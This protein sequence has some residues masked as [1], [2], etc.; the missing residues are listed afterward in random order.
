MLSLTRSLILG[1]QAAAL[2]AVGVLLSAVAAQAQTIEWT[3][4]PNVIVPAEIG[5]NTIV[6]QG[7]QIMFDAIAD[8]LY[9]RYNGNC[10][11]QVLYRLLIGSLDENSQPIDVI[12]YPNERWFEANDYQS[13]IL[14]TA[15][16]A[17]Q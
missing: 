1:S 16:E 8:G 10:Q 11:S 5:T 12:D 7:N 6:R 2:A 3:D 4:V 17:S 14:A 13:A 15:C 9:V